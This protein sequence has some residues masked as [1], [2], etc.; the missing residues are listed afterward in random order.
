MAISSRVKHLLYVHKALSPHYLFKCNVSMHSQKCI[1]CNGT[2]NISEGEKVKGIFN[3]RFGLSFAETGWHDDI[4]SQ[5][6]EWLGFLT[7]YSNNFTIKVGEKSE[8]I[9]S[10]Y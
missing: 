6:G 3:H 9:K 5:Q 4:T 2:K 10:I 8:N 7:S 1:Y